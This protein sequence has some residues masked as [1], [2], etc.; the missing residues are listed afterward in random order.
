MFLDKIHLVVVVVGGGDE[1][2]T[3]CEFFLSNSLSTAA[4]L[5]I[6]AVELIVWCQISTTTVSV[7]KISQQAYVNAVEISP[8]HHRSQ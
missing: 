4:R 2:L 1:L 3:F 8:S 6:V 5:C 7:L